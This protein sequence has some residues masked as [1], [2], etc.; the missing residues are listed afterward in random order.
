MSPEDIAVGVVALNGGTLVGRTRLQKT[1]F[2]LDQC[3]MESG[4]EFEYLHYGPYCVDLAQG[5]D[6]AKANKRLAMTNPLGRYGVPYTVF[7]TTRT[8]PPSNLGNLD[9][10]RA[11]AL[12]GE[13][14]AA[15]DVVLELAATIVYLREHGYDDRAIDEVKIRKPVK[16]T[17]V[18]LRKATDLLRRLGLASN[19]RMPARPERPSASLEP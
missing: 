13:M 16:A 12:I 11:K 15:S 17:E 10:E 2:L 9:A 19:G 3:G 1:V 18:R 6:D 5:W 4:L 8:A 14:S 7:E